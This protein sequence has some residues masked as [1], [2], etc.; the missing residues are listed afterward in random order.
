M[1]DDADDDLEVVPPLPD[2]NWV[3]LTATA[4]QAMEW[5]ID[6]SGQLARIHEEQEIVVG[7]IS[8][9]TIARSRFDQPTLPEPDP[10]ATN[11]VWQD[12]AALADAIRDLVADPPPEF[13]NALLPPYATALALGQ[14]LQDAQRDMGLPV[15]PIP[16]ER[17][18]LTPLGGFPL[19]VPPEPQTA[20]AES[21]PLPDVSA[22]R[23]E[24]QADLDRRPNPWVLLA[25]VVVVAVIAVVVGV[26][27]R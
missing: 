14:E 4:Q 20:A 12:I 9:G 8:A 1:T 2:R 26:G 3:G 17:A 23:P 7:S 5:G 27:W 16:Y 15:A 6:L 21:A 22:L 24:V 11:A 19:E 25:I 18:P 10:N 13:I